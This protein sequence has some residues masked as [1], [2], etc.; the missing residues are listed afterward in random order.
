MSARQNTVLHYAFGLV[1]L[2]ACCAVLQIHNPAPPPSAAAAAKQVVVFSDPALEAAVRVHLEI[3]AG[4]THDNRTDVES[5]VTEGLN[6]P[7]GIALDLGPSTIPTLS[8][9][10]LAVTTFVLLAAGAVVIARRGR[11]AAT[12]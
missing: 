9:W 10:G 11:L 12:A 6:H 1:L 5:L 2:A 3:P 4:E 7:Q 8:E